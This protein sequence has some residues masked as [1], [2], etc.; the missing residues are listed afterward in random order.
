MKYVI[1]FCL[2]VIVCENLLSVQDD[3]YAV[4][5]KFGKNHWK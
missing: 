4:D 1:P 2:I 3:Q 5:R